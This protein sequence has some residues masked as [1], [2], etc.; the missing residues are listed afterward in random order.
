MKKTVMVSFFCLLSGVVFGQSLRQDITGQTLIENAKAEKSAQ[1]N[2]AVKQGAEIKVTPDGKSFYVFWKPENYSVST[3]LIVSIH[4]HGSWTTKD[5]YMWYPYI[6][7]RGYAILTLQWWKGT[8][9]ETKDYLRPEEMYRM[10]D[11]ILTEKKIEAPVLLHGFSRGSANT[12]ALASLDVHSGKRHFDLFIANAGK[13]NPGYPPNKAIQSGKMGPAPLAGTRW[14]TVAGGKDKNQDRDG[15]SAMRETQAWL[16]KYGAEIV[17][18]IEDPN[19]DH[20]VF[21]RNPKNVALA[22]DAFDKLIKQ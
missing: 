3:P 10:L 13:A 17:L 2:F 15:I 7:E 16:K 22:L 18:A 1:Y 14:I 19:G 21:H 9:E 8:G 12:Y 20:G 5:F 6:K 4:G 11:Q